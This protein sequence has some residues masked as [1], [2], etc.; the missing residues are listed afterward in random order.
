MVSHVTEFVE[1]NPTI[2]IALF[3]SVPCASPTKATSPPC[4]ETVPG[5]LGPLQKVKRETSAS[6]T[7][8]PFP[9]AK[10]AR[11]VAPAVPGPGGGVKE[12]GVVDGFTHIGEFARSVPCS[13]LQ[14][15]E[16]VAFC[17]I[18]PWFV[19]VV[20]PNPVGKYPL[21]QVVVLP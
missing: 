14:S 5:Q 2:A 20:P 1:G 16:P 8:S 9:T 10:L 12:A 7:T 18:L 13:E 15:P 17:Q 4:G 21:G 19:G 3:W 11:L 6:K